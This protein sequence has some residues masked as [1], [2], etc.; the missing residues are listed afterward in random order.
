MDY[1]DLP[2]FAPAEEPLASPKKPK[3]KTSKLDPELQAELHKRVPTS[4]RAVRHRPVMDTSSSSDEET[5]TETTSSSEEYANPP[6][7]PGSSPDDY[8]FHDIPPQRPKHHF[9]DVHDPP[10]ELRDPPKKAVPPTPDQLLPPPVVSTPGRP[11]VTSPH[12][13]GPVRRQITPGRLQSWATPSP[14]DF[15]DASFKKSPLCMVK[16]FNWFWNFLGAY[17]LKSLGSKGCKCKRT[18]SRKIRTSPFPTSNLSWS[19]RNQKIKFFFHQQ[20]EENQQRSPY[21]SPHFFE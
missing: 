15:Q 8:H 7:R 18:S 10:L 19:S 17:C 9:D 2:D 20:H 13:K 21:S 5:T 6:P 4:G 11:S 12:G 16:V 1:L 3:H 14:H